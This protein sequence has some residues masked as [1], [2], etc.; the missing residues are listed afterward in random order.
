MKN[1]NYSEEVTATIVAAYAANPNMETVKDLA[2]TFNKTTKSII[3]K[4]SREGVYQKESY[5]TK[6][7]AKPVTKIE[8]VTQ[9]ADYLQI[10]VEAVAGLEKSPKAALQKVVDVLTIN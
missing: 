4:L 3:G 6:T 5:T 2:A 8:L 9:L 10:D 1:V 7:G